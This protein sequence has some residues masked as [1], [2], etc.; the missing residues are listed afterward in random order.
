MKKQLEFIKQLKQQA[1][2]DYKFWR[3]V[4]LIDNHKGVLKGILRNT[5]D[6]I[7]KLYIA[8]FFDYREDYIQLDDFIDV[9]ERWND[10]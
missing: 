9:L 2:N 4:T 8:G 5:R 1:L 6:I 10:A 7:A 3:K